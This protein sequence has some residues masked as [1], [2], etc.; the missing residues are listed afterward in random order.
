MHA[1]LQI[2]I[3]EAK[4][5]S[6][7]RKTGVTHEAKKPMTFLLIHNEASEK[8]SYDGTLEDFVQVKIK[9]MKITSVLL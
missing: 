8:E 6:Y 4:P 9:K 2:R 7:P 3:S 1:N 5:G